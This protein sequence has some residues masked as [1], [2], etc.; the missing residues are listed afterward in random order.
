LEAQRQ[1]II[2]GAGKVGKNLVQL[3]PQ[4]WSI[5]LIDLSEEKLS[6]FADFPNVRTICRD[7]SSR[8]VLQK[9]EPTA[10]TVVFITAISDELN[11]ECARV[12]KEAFHTEEIVSILQNPEELGAL[13]ENE[14]IDISKIVALHMSNQ[15]AATTFKGIGIGLGKGEIRQ[16][17]V[18]T[19]SAAIGMPLKELKP[20]RWLVAAIYRN[21]SLI[22]P[23]GDSTLQARDRVLLV[24]DPEILDSEEQFIRGG[25]VLFPTQYGQN[26]G[27]IELE[28][29]HKQEMNWLE[30]NTLASHSIQLKAQDFD[31]QKK[32]E[33]MISKSLHTDNIGCLILP[34]K[35]ISWVARMGL[36]RSPQN[37]IL[38][39]SRVPV[40]IPRGTLPY[41][42]ILMAVGT[43]EH[44]PT[45]A[46]IAVDLSRQ[47]EAS[48]TSL[49][50]VTPHSD[51]KDT[52]E[53]EKI[54]KKIAQIARSNGIEL[55][56]VVDKGNPIHKIRE[57][58]ANYDL[59]ILGYSKASR[60]NIFNPDISMHLLHD[61]PCSTLFIP[62]DAARR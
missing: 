62:W 14:V 53:L 40:L 5:F 3:L 51:E 28:E 22:V 24:G 9:A 31:V 17:T 54:P 34:P 12:I 29:K 39:S 10:S 15:V 6:S 52:E 55:E 41:K 2:V 7:A 32:E 18:L 37:Q 25:R 58:A 50:I 16:I 38:L 13:V 56:R 33:E 4:T 44:A 42:K 11:K 23:H 26:I 46:S 21:Q 43:Q 48:L 27:Y 45:V 47:F 30:E 20:Q 35:P 49:S 36:T 57:H 19:S 59:L 60:N 8:L 61:T 1:A